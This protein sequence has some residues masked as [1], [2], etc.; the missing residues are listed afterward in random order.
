M[1]DRKGYS[2][3]DSFGDEI[4]LYPRLNMYVEGNS[5]YLGFDSFD[6]EAGDMEPYCDATVN[7]VALPYLHSCIDTNNNGDKMLDFLV[8]NGFGEPL[9]LRIPSGFCRYPVFRFNEEKLREI[10]PVVLA[11]YAK[12]HGI[13]KSSLDV[14]IGKAQ[15]CTDVQNGDVQKTLGKQREAEIALD[16]RE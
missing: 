6:S 3:V 12:A 7:I 11:A 13:D 15:T 5:L 10:D 4:I 16:D 2:Y 8:R 14:Q 9:G 1:S